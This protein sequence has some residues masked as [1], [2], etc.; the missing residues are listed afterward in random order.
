MENFLLLESDLLYDKA[1]LITLIQAPEENIILSSGKTNSNDE[2]YIEVD[3]ELNL[4]NMSK[5]ATSL[6]S[7][8]GE[9][10]GIAK[11]SF[12]LYQE[13]CLAFEKADNIKLEYEVGLVSASLAVPIRVLKIEDYAWCEIDDESHLQRA[14]EQVYGKI[15]EREKDS[16]I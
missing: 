1:G 6:V 16:G 5:D 8:Y 9:L 2:V 14:I 7:I 13:M 11:V 10:V 4:V 15:K 3:G 12:D